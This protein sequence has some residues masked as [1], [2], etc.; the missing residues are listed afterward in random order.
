VALVAQEIPKV[1]LVMEAVKVVRWLRN[2]GDSVTLGEPLVEV[3]TEKSM[4]E[5]EATASGRLMQILV[6][7]DQEATVGDRLAWIETGEAQPATAAAN[8]AHIKESDIDPLRPTAPAP[9]STAPAAPA[10]PAGERIRSSPIARKLAAERGLDLGAIAGT[11]PGG[12]VQL[13]DVMRAI[14]TPANST[15]SNPVARGAAAGSPAPGLQRLSPMR[16]ALARAMTLSNASIPQF[17]VERSVDWTG[18]QALRAEFTARLA[19]GAPRLSVT[20]FLLQAVARALIEFPALNATFSGDPAS[21]DAGVLPASG[22]H[23]GL[24]LAVDNGLLVPVIHHVERLGLAELARRRVDCVERGLQGRLK[25]EEVDGA[26]FSISNLG[27]QGPDRF[28]ALINPPQSAIL[29]VGRQRDRVV[30]RDAR[31]V[32]RA[33]SVLTLTVD[34]RIADGR[35][36]SEFLARL[37][38][39]LEG[40][41]WRVD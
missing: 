10:V 3:E 38:G 21:P 32:M 35:L 36:A 6:Q 13:Q 19:P 40:R 31:I 25:R 22:A 41:D 17:T 9:A 16:R 4:V 1:G 24:A 12:R 8:P 11:G 34:H 2:V 30:V 26:T 37:I 20:D 14:E 29:A 7:V 33:Q 23:I 15:A 39:I 18:L 27:A 28:T 5:I